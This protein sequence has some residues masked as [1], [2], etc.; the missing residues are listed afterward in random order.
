M[1]AAKLC[2][3]CEPKYNSAKLVTSVNRLCRLHPSI[4]LIKSD[5]IK[6]ENG[7]FY[8]VMLVCL[9][10][11]IMNCRNIIPLVD[12]LRFYARKIDVKTIV[13]NEF[14]SRFSAERP[15]ELSTSAANNGGG[16]HPRH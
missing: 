12:A 2:K 10:F 1:S 3:N 7:C 4:I 15:L 5:I 14:K 6:T 11:S 9:N 16:S 13:F 8:G